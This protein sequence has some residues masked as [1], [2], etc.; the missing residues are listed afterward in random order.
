MR[1]ISY[2]KLTLSEIPYEISVKTCF[3]LQNPTIA[4]VLS[5]TSTSVEQA[6][7]IGGICNFSYPFLIAYA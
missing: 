7:T 1:K 5:N 3:H 4:G 2:Q 6:G